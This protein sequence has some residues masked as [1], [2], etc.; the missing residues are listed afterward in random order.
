MLIYMAIQSN[1]NKRWSTLKGKNKNRK[2]SAISEGIRI[3][4][5]GTSGQALLHET[6]PIGRP[7]AGHRT[8]DPSLPHPPTCFPAYYLFLVSN[9]RHKTLYT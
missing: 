9:T 8:G 5:E 7:D 6:P 3:K 4:E 1:L 2:A